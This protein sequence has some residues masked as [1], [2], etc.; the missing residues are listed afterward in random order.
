MIFVMTR[1]TELVANLLKDFSL[2]QKCYAT[3]RGLKWDNE[4]LKD[5]YELYFDH[6]ITFNQSRIVAGENLLESI[7]KDKITIIYEYNNSSGFE[8]I[9]VFDESTIDKI[10]FDS[11]I[12]NAYFKCKTTN[13]NVLIAEIEVKIGY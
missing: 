2:V 8:D 6:D 1:K 12:F 4:L 10:E 5:T 13:N 11:K 3:S 9:I 7:M